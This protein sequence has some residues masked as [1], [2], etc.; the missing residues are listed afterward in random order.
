MNILSYNPGNFDELVRFLAR[1]NREGIHYI[2][3]LGEQKSEITH[4][5]ELFT[6][7]LPD[8]FQLAYQDSCLCGALGVE[9][10]HDV[11]R[12][13]LHGPF[14]DAEDWQAVADRLYVE[15]VRSIPCEIR[16]HEIYCDARNLDCR[17]FAERQG[18]T[19]VN[20]CLILSL[21]R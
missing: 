18:F 1:L 9:Y 12:A 6:Q 4:N 19:L 17:M 2:G 8:G 7:P 3:Y 10:D 5:L 11:A 16:E 14:C 21:S 20:E 13:W 15:T